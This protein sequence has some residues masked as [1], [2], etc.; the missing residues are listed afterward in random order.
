MLTALQ[1]GITSSCCPAPI[2]LLTN[3]LAAVAKALTMMKKNDDTL[4]NTFVIANE[5]SPR[6]SIAM[7][8]RNQ[9]L[10]EINACIM[11]QIEIFK[12]RLS[13]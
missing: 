8:K 4:R 2:K 7:K 10:M 9:V 5:R 13:K 6:C 11:V 1:V 12:I 3:E